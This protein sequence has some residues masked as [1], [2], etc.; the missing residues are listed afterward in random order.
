MEE[1]SKENGKK[2]NPYFGMGLIAFIFLVIGGLIIEP[3]L[4]FSSMALIALAVVCAILDRVRVLPRALGKKIVVGFVPAAIV[5]WIG[6]DFIQNWRVVPTEEYIEDGYGA[7]SYTRRTVELDERSGLELPVEALRIDGATSLYDLYYSYALAVYN[8]SSILGVHSNRTPRAYENL[9]GGECDLIFAFKPS[10]AQI[11]AAAAAGKKL[12]ITPIGHDAFVFFVNAANP[13][14]SLTVPQIK[15]IYTGRMSNWRGAGGGDDAIIPFQ[16]FEGSGS[17]SRMERFMAGEILLT[18]DREHRIFNMLGIVTRVARY[19]NYRHAIGYSY[20]YYVNVMMEGGGVKLLAV[21]GIRPT[22]STLRDGS[23]PLAEEICIVTAG[24][25]KPEVGR[26]IEWVLSPQGQAMMETI[27][28]VPIRPV[29]EGPDRPKTRLV[30]KK[31][32]NPPIHQ[33]L[34]MRSQR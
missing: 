26:F 5:F 33:M 28:L 18:P 9:I 24:S 2:D 19:K 32:L 23:Y 22:P 16:R 8:H 15:D 20:L 21:D 31:G 25:G 30:V 3:R 13:V 14:D 12:E 34:F 1:K 10:E 7:A 6:F 29:A 27:G 11:A 4:L 17:Q